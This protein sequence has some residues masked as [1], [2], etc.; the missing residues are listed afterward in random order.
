MLCTDEPTNQHSER[1]RIFFESISKKPKN[2]H[3]AQ[4]PKVFSVNISE[5]IIGK[6]VEGWRQK[7]S[8]R[9]LQ[10]SNVGKDRN[11]VS[12]GEELGYKN[13]ETENFEDIFQ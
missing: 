5:S 2:V 6:L 11:V 7:Q 3:L 1:N 12:I 9:F 4:K 13:V 10:L 8:Y